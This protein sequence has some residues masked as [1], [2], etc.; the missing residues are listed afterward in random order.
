M[1]AHSLCCHRPQRLFPR[2]VTALCTVYPVTNSSAWERNQPGGKNPGELCHCVLV[3]LAS[4]AGGPHLIF[5]GSGW[6]VTATVFWIQKIPS[7][8]SSWWGS[9]CDFCWVFVFLVMEWPLSCVASSF[10]TTQLM[11]FFNPF[12]DLSCDYSFKSQ[13]DILNPEVPNLQSPHCTGLPGAVNIVP[14][15]CQGFDFDTFP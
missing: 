5:W 4:H 2:L 7:F 1:I 11:P 10:H 9:A 15:S 12:P 8:P 14:D 13:R 6:C 3:S